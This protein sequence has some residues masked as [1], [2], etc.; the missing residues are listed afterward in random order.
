M[1]QTSDSYY[2]LHIKWLLWATIGIQGQ[3]MMVLQKCEIIFHLLYEVGTVGM[4]L[5]GEIQEVVMVMEG[6]R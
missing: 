5:Q 2:H 3:Q 6:T 4:E 1:P